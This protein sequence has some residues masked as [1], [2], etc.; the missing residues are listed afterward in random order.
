MIVRAPI[1]K[2]G[3]MPELTA[4]ELVNGPAYKSVPGPVEAKPTPTKV[5]VSE[6]PVAV[7]KVTAA[8]LE[9][10]SAVIAQPPVVLATATR[11]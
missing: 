6:P 4:K 3:V 8:T 7:G 9:I 1:A 11:A 5:S 10:V 2:L